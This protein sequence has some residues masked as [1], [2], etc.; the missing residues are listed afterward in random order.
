MVLR[1]A[2]YRS[3]ALHDPLAGDNNWS[4]GCRIY[5]RSCNALLEASRQWDWLGIVEEGQQFIFRIG[6]VPVRFFHGDSE[7]PTNRNLEVAPVEALQIEMCYGDNRV[8]LIWRIAVET[9]QVGEVRRIVL[10]GAHS[11]G[12]IDIHF[13]IPV[14]EKLGVFAPPKPS[15]KRG[16]Q[17][18]PATVTVLTQKRVNESDAN[19][20]NEPKV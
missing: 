11:A 4:L 14:N 20:G 13:P 6:A 9:N 7:S 17:L 18:P 2:R 12:G 15:G 5:A 3:L 10:I 19:D 8:D 1:E 16:V